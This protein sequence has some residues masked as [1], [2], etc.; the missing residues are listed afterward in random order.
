MGQSEIK[1]S[2]KER[3]AYTP[4]QVAEIKRRR[5]EKNAAKNTLI[6][7]ILASKADPKLKCIVLTKEMIELAQLMAPKNGGG[8]G[9]G[10]KVSM[11]NQVK[12][13][14]E[15]KDVIDEV[16][17]FNALHIGRG[18][19]AK[20]T[21]LLI[22]NF[23]PETRTWINFDVEDGEYIVEGRGAVAPEG[24]TG[25]TPVE[26]IVEASTDDGQEVANEDEE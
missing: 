10:G 20:I 7:L 22:K 5:D 19:M 23:T 24:W 8:T 12:A 2:T 16:E 6:Q 11:M 14:F 18:E 4:E 1:M 9:S 21:K 25:Y 13:L 3:K 26:E 17:L 15:T